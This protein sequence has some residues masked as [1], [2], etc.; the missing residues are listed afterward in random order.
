MGI[1]AVDILAG[2]LLHGFD[3]STLSIPWTAGLRGG[4]SSMVALEN[5]RVSEGVVR[6]WGFRVGR[7][8]KLFVRAQFADAPQGA[9][10]DI[11][12]RA[13]QNCGAVRRRALREIGSAL[14]LCGGC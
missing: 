10:W 13:K 3:F 11:Q 2:V 12:A 7:S 9:Y 1:V 8:G 14:A 5:V 4:V 6:N